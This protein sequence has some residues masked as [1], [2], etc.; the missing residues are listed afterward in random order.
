MSFP[1]T[2]QPFECEIVGIDFSRRVPAG[3]TIRPAEVGVTDV[4]IEETIPPPNFITANYGGHLVISSIVLTGVTGREKILTAKLSEGV[5]NFQY[6]VT[7]RITLSDGQKKE[8][9]LLVTIKET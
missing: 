2:K 7:F 3:V 4:Q 9:D 6:R 8:D 5:T 1:Y